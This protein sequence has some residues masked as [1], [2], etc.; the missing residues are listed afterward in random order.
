MLTSVPSY[1]HNVRL[2]LFLSNSMATPSVEARVPSVDSS[3]YAGTI[4][5]DQMVYQKT[6][7]KGN[8]NP[9]H[10]RDHALKNSNCNAHGVPF[11]SQDSLP[12]ANDS[13]FSSTSVQTSNGWKRKRLNRNRQVKP[14]KTL[15]P[16]NHRMC[17]DSTYVWAY[18]YYVRACLVPW[19]SSLYLQ[20]RSYHILK[21]TL[22]MECF[23]S[24]PKF[25][26]RQ[27]FIHSSLLAINSKWE[28]TFFKLLSRKSSQ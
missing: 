21:P 14:M 1:Q 7:H 9:R 15:L 16:S 27:T 8:K 12:R 20:K 5:V 18:L 4:D 28:S 24:L 23:E 6:I 25:P 13:R 11:S 26:T 17:I 2:L 10:T 22:P 3:S 19:S